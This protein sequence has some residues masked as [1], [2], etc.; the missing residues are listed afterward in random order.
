[1]KNLKKAVALV[2][3][4]TMILC[5]AACG[6]EIP[7]ETKPAASAQTYTITVHSQG[8][9]ALAGVEAYVYA[10]NSLSDL[11][12]FGQTNENGSLSLNML[13][14]EEYA[15]VLSGVPNGYSCQETY[16]FDGTNA[17]ITLHSALITGESLSSA[18]LGVG[19]V[20]YDFS[21]VLPDGS[22]WTLSEELAQKEMVLINFFFTTCGPCAN[23]FPFMQQAYDQFSDS[24]GVIALDP[25]EDNQAVSTYQA[26]MGLT[27]P[28]AACPAVWSQT[29]GISGYPTSVVVDRYGVICLVEVGAI[30]SLRPF[31]AIFEHFSTPD[32]E[33]K[34]LGSV[35]ELIANVKPNC[36]MPSSQELGVTLGSDAYGIT[37]RAESNPDDAEYA[38]PF[39]ITEKNGEACIKASNQEIEASFA[40][41]YADVQLQAGQ[42]ICFDYL[43]STE[44]GCDILFVIVDGQDVL[45]ISGHDEVETWKT[46]YPWVAQA[47][48]IH[49][50]ALCYLKDGDTSEA[51]DTVYLKNFRVVDSAEIDTPTYIPRQ[52]AVETDDFTWEYAQIVL[53][54]KD[55][56]YHVG[57]ADGPLLLAD[58][59]NYTQYNE[60]Q[61]IWQLCFDGIVT[62]DGAPIYDD[63]VNYFSYASNSQLSGV[64]TVNEELAQWLTLVDECT[65]FDLE[66]D[67][68]WLKA[69]KYYEAYGT[70]TQLSDPIAGLATFSAYE[71][72]LGK[73]VPS[74]YFYYDRP[75]MPRGLLARFTPEKSGV[76]LISSRCDS[77]HGVEGWIFGEDRGAGHYTYTPDVRTVPDTYNVYMYYY[78]E[79][80]QN[81]YIDIAFWDI[82]EVNTVYYDIEYIALSA[83]VFRSASPGYF[84][85]DTNATGDQMYALISGGIDVVLGEDGIYYEDLGN[86]QKGSKIYCDFT[87]ITGVFSNPIT[88]VPACNEDGTPVLDADGQPVMVKG[89]IEMGGFDFS[90]TEDDLYIL[91]I[92]KKYDGDTQAADAYLKALWG[93]DYD[94][95]YASYQVKDV[96]AG[97]YHGR[98]EDYT[99]LMEKFL[100]QMITSGPA[101]RRGC[102]VVTEELAQILQMLMDKYTFSGVDHSW[103]KLCYYYD[104]IGPQ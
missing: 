61:T 86:G 52:A 92:L 31:T 87:G 26:G 48:G 20:M 32:Y 74:N 59:M 12:A 67:Y 54:K 70:D 100:D 50:V 55:G 45:A 84:T 35:S 99:P 63:M 6:E 90:K 44:R 41:L 96:F 21:V 83:E 46:C 34:L 93:E 27:F 102:V 43:S 57:S 65:G 56:Y 91:S 68:E 39:V 19:D 8:G 69:C 78:M 1:M 42:A 66:D 88:S 89:M 98:G 33:Q 101:E 14:S 11:V 23:E 29:F 82:Y 30:T 73:N 53:N 76:Y 94:A 95:N 36:T 80:G 13:P 72:K 75:I 38:W 16:T 9:M 7:E 28:M 77:D 81:Y 60:E 103:T 47:D 4:L 97:R 37:Y 3:A 85:Y 79:A 22:E 104:Y 10:D 5:F 24:V 17:A 49:E 64:C 71:A 25:L 15:I 62:R 2:L 40:I 51:D 18:S 58:L